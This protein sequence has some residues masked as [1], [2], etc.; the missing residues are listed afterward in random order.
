MN[1]KQFNAAIKRLN[2]SK[3]RDDVPTAVRGAY[4][5][6]TMDSNSEPLSRTV[7]AIKHAVGVRVAWRLLDMGNGN[8]AADK[9]LIPFK[10][11]NNVAVGKI[12]K[13]KRDWLNV[14]LESGVTRG[15]AKL[16]SNIDA[17]LASLDGDKAAKDKAAPDVD[18]MFANVY[19]KAIKAGFTIAQCKAANTK[20]AKAATAKAVATEDKAA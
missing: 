3:T 7:A 12:D 19:A 11:E 1:T 20:A 10:L 15:R 13:T 6:F 16:E 9:G 5:A 17:W 18:K 8:Q 4:E 14:V 2:T